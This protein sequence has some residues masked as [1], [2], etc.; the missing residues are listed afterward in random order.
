MARQ[1]DFDASPSCCSSPSACASSR[2]ARM[3]SAW[4]SHK[5]PS[6]MASHRTIACRTRSDASCELPR[7]AATSSR[8]C[9]QCSSCE[10]RIRTC[11]RQQAGMEAQVSSSRSPVGILLLLTIAS[12]CSGLSACTAPQ[13]EH[14]A[15]AAATAPSLHA[16]PPL[17]FHPSSSASTLGGDS[18]RGHLHVNP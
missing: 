4:C 5:R 8:P 10:S 2:L 9:F 17:H 11:D 6:L 13:C 3:R 14:D 12:R 7:P 1:S 15:C 18:Q 16:S